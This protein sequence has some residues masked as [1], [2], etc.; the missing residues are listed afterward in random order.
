MT[1]PDTA[2]VPLDDLRELLPDWKRHLRAANKA[3]S[4]INSYLLI[5]QEFLA[6]LL[7]SGMPTSASAITREHIEHYLVHLQER[8]H[9][10]TGKPLSAANIA[11]HYRSL[12]QLF[13]WLDEVEGEIEASPFAKMSPPAVPEQPVDVLTED[14]LRALVNACKGKTFEQRRDEALVR[15]FI[16]TGARI[17]EIA[18][19]RVDDI[20][21]DAD[22]AHVMGKGRRARAV[23]FGSK[24]G[25][26]LRRYLR[27]RS[28]QKPAAGRDEL[29]IGRKGPLKEYGIRQVLRRRAEDAGVPNVH[30]HRFRHSF[31]HRWLADGGQEQDLM[32]LAGWRSREMVGRYGASAADER[33]REAHR[34]MGL[35]DQL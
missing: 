15:M 33:A 20:D 31:A 23:P 5:A 4:T 11:K 2:A 26:A 35:G 27:A 7:D 19:L 24:T 22:V 8:P 14:Q 18:P 25:E 9:K 1:T 10:R 21:F 12:Q 32:R 3:P 17:G 28:R 6:F 16:D 34:R 29:W 30:P 13:R